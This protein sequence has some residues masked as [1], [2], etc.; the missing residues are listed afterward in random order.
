MSEI[1]TSVHVPKPIC[2]VAEREHTRYALAAVQ[3]V[4]GER[5]ETAWL[6]ATNSRI[7]AVRRTR[8]TTDAPQL[9]PRG[10]MPT[11]KEGT[12]VELNGRWENANGQSAKPEAEG[13][14]FPRIDD[15]MPVPTRDDLE[16][17]RF[18]ALSV[19]A[20]LLRKLADAISGDGIVTMFVPAARGVYSPT[21]MPAVDSAIPVVGPDGFGAIM[22]LT[23]VSDERGLERLK[24]DVAEYRQA[25]KAE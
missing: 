7:A 6:A 16:H 2:Q 14:R 17:G 23:S 20:R 8:G 24:Q 25:F 1:T 15:Y 19:D 3:V 10:V 13:A 18:H 9:I 4:P 11:R 22:P 21:Y 5:N 12:L